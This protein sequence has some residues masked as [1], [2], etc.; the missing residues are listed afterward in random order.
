MGAVENRQTLLRMYDA[1]NDLDLEAGLTA[2]AEDV[3]VHGLPEEFGRGL[4]SARRAVSMYFEAFPDLRH[5]VLDL[6]AEG[7]MVVTR[8]RLTGTHGGEFLG[9]PASSRT[10]EWEDA[11]FFR[12]N[13]AGK[14]AENWTYVDMLAVLAQIG[15]VPEEP[16]I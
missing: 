11:D 8:N 16:A 12:F 3:V 5:E 1:F 14:I 2:F 15:L 4:D 10:I 9:V 7:D 13:D 6:V